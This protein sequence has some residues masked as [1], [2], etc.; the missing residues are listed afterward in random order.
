MKYENME[1]QYE[2]GMVKRTFCHTGMNGGGRNACIPTTFIPVMS[3][4]K[5]HHSGMMV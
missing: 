5:I 2:S 3:T 4:E 1:W